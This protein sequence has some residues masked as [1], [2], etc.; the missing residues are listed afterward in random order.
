M[1]QDNDSNGKGI[2]L[3]DFRLVPMSLIE[4]M[5]SNLYKANQEAFD[6]YFNLDSVRRQNINLSSKKEE[7]KEDATKEGVT[8]KEESNDNETPLEKTE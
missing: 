8:E 6:L 7:P 5:M 2:N 1:T 4:S 3:K